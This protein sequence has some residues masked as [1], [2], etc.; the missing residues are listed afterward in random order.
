M[1]GSVGLEVS[2]DDGSWTYAMRDAVERWGSWC[3]GTWSLQGGSAVT[4][5]AGDYCT[6]MHRRNRL[7]HGFYCPFGVK[8]GLGGRSVTERGLVL[9][10]WSVA[11]LGGGDRGTTRAGNDESAE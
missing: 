9:R 5:S 4:A 3:P 10:T 8:A 6:P 7:I 11:V 1:V 2:G